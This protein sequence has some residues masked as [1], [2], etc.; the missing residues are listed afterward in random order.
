MLK[1]THS[2]V[3]LMMFGKK[4]SDG[5]DNDDESA[6]LQSETVD[7]DEVALVDEN[8]DDGEVALVDE[9]VDDEVFALFRGGRE[10]SDVNL[11]S[12]TPCNPSNPPYPSPSCCAP[13]K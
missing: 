13:W 10:A 1:A 9:N 7:D 5:G 11:A 6:A 2:K 8:I 3:K 12:P 4:K